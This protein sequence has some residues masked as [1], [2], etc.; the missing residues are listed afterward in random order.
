M[1]DDLAGR[2][3]KSSSGLILA[4]WLTASLGMVLLSIHAIKQRLWPDPDDSLRLQEVRDWLAGQSWF[5]VTQYRMNPPQG[6]PMHWSRLVDVPLGAIMLLLRPLLGSE[7][8]ELAAVVIVPLLTLGVVTL[9]T[10]ILARRLLDPQSSLLAAV[11][12]PFCVSA[13]NQMR[14]LRID[15]HGWQI[16]AGL[17]ATIGVLDDRP[18][19]GA[20]L[21]AGAMA[22]WLNISLEGMPFAAAIGGLFAIRWLLDQSETGRLRWYCGGLATFSLLLFAITH[23]PEAWGQKFHDVIMPAHLA[24]FSA[25]AVAILVGVRTGLGSRTIRLLVLAAA[26]AVALVAMYAVD[27]GS[28]HGP[29]SQ[30]D[31]LVR[32]FWYDRVDEGLPLWALSPPTALVAVVQPVLGLAGTALLHRSENVPEVRRRQVDYGILLSAALAMTVL[33]LRASLFAV[34]LALPGLGY[35]GWKVLKRARRIPNA[36]PRIPATI[37]A[38]F[39]MFPTYVVGALFLLMSAAIGARN[40][41]AI[42]D[43]AAAQCVT[44]SE[45]DQL[46]RLPVGKIAAP[47]DLGPAIIVQTRDSVIASGH[48]RNL[49]GMRDNILL[50][51]LPPKQAGRIVQDRQI[52]YVITCPWMGELRSY[53]RANPTSLASDLISAQPPAWLER[54]N[55]PGLRQLQVWRVRKDLLEPNPPSKARAAAR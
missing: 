14:P 4:A 52:D 17:L 50:F 7:N 32:K 39:V 23:T 42:H 35:I 45:L 48:H 43:E 30:L 11:S 54:V 13:W 28:F 8:A 37:G 19:K 22:V 5:D 12:T 53:A 38:A 49:I 24:A 29:F 33:L 34:V 16:A 9:L 47:L 55:L 40:S 21:A 31:P 6:V 51:L 10:T 44:R 27:S 25:A 46:N 3:S 2:L 1:N 36:L 20:L 18:K 41:N 26:G 15:H